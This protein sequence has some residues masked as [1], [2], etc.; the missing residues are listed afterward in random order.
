MSI[1]QVKGILASLLLV[2]ATGE[3]AVRYGWVAPLGTGS[4]KT[5]KY[6]HMATIAALPGG[7]LAAAF[8]CTTTIEGADDQH[9]RFTV[10]HDTGV[11][12]S[13]PVPTVGNTTAG[14]AVWGPSLFFDGGK[15]LF[16]FYSVSP[17]GSHHEVGGELRQIISKDQGETWSKPMTILALG[18]IRKVTANK[19]AVVNGTWLLP[20]WYEGQPPEGGASVLASS[21]LGKSWAPHGFIHGTNSSS[22]VNGTKVIENSV[23]LTRSGKV[24]QIYRAGKGFL[25]SSTS[26]D[27]QG[28]RWSASA[29]PTSIPNPNSKASLFT[30][31]TGSIILTYN[32]SQT[33]RSPLALAESKTGEVGDFAPLV[34]LEDNDNRS[35]AYPTSSAV[36][37]NS[38]AYTIFSVYSVYDPHS[39]APHTHHWWGIRIAAYTVVTAATAGGA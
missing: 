13:D 24:L 38:S 32:P 31:P 34:T 3:N 8:Q 11:S 17:A 5:I 28:L 39:T 10:S 12:W 37:I 22:K 14:P 15:R 18:D 33:L 2:L 1:K 4:L 25:F 29:L 35:F 26:D 9:I 36:A 23:A 20:F 21:D 16:M 7:I 30:S 19:V 27:S 6:S